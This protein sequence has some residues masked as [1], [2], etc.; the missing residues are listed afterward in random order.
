MQK[1]TLSGFEKYGKTT[2]R[3]QFL[4]DMDQ[5]IPWP[6]LAA[7]V[8]SWGSH[9][10]PDGPAPRVASGAREVRSPHASA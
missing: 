2:R 1:Q 3:A 5:I 7:A 4:A 10:S 9:G 8:H 6:E